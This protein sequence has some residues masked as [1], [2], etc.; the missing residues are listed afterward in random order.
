M[1]FRQE[2]L[3]QE[4]LSLVAAVAFIDLKDQQSLENNMCLYILDFPRTEM[5]GILDF[6]VFDITDKAEE[7]AVY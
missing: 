6:L 2:G 5:G 7:Q 4:V 1:H 3:R